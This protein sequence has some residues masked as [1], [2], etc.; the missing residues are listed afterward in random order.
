MRVFTVPSF[1]AL[2]PLIPAP[3]MSGRGWELY[4]SAVV[5]LMGTQQPVK[6]SGDGPLNVTPSDG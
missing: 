6:P 4:R 2:G 3:F 1:G 5:A